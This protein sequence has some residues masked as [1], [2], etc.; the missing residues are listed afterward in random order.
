MNKESVNQYR[1]DYYIKN[2]DKAIENAKAWAKQN[3][4]KMKDYRRKYYIKN[5]ERMKQQIYQWRLE[6]PEKVA[7]YERDRRVKNPNYFRQKNNERYR[8]VME[9]TECAKQICPAFMFL[10]NIRMIDAGLYQLAY[11]PKERVVPKVAK[12]CDAL[13]TMDAKL[14][15]L[16]AREITDTREI[17]STCPMSGAF[18]IDGAANQIAQIAKLLRGKCHG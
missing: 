11:K 13:G 16:V 5:K 1:K 9:M 8:I 10:T 17:E 6:H 2:K 7:E 3:P 4:D 14:C 18:K 15:P 12:V